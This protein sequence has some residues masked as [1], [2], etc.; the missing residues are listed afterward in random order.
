MIPVLLHGQSAG[1][2]YRMKTVVIDA[3]HGGKDP[4]NLGTGRYKW[5]EKNV[6]LDVTMK[7]GSYIKE[8]FPDINVIYTRD[9]DE[10][11]GLNERADIANSAK[12]DIFISIHCN[13]VEYPSARGVET[14]AL[15]LHRNEENLQVAMKENSAI[16]LEDDYEN[17]YD[18]F[19]PNSPESIIALTMMQSAF[20]DQSLRISSYIQKQFK[21][22]VGR[23]DRGVKQAGFLVLR[24]TTMPSIL[25]ELGFLTNP[26]EEDFLNSESGRVYMA[27]AIL[28]GFKEYKSTVEDPLGKEADKEDD[29]KIVSVDL[30]QAELKAEL[31]RK[32]AELAL[33]NG[34][35][36]AAEAAKIAK[37]D[38]IKVE[39][40]KKV[41]ASNAKK[42]ESE[43][44]AEV[45][46]LK[47]LAE[48]EK[49][50]K[51]EISAKAKTDSLA[52][53]RNKAKSAKLARDQAKV[54]SL[55]IQKDKI[56]AENAQAEAKKKELNR[57]AELARLSELALAEEKRLAE[58]AV[59]IEAA[60]LELTKEKTEAA[61]LAQDQA[62]V[63]SLRIQ[64]EKAAAELTVAASRK[65][66]ELD[67]IEAE[68]RKADEVNQ[69]KIESDK[70][71]AEEEMLQ[72]A[73]IR[74]E[75]EN[76]AKSAKQEEIRKILE[77]N[78][79]DLIAETQEQKNLNAEK[80]AAEAANAQRLEDLRK[81][82]LEIEA[83]LAK[84]QNG[85]LELAQKTV[86]Q[87]EIVEP[88]VEKVDEKISGT[89]GLVFKVQIHTATKP[90][91]ASSSLF[92][93]VQV[94]EY[95]QGDLYKYTTGDF[96]TVEQ[97]TPTQAKMRE[98]GFKGAFVVAFKDGQR[99][100]VSVARALLKQ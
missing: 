65:Q 98:L 25:I 23:K 21:E 88:V 18:G 49:Q 68:N 11:I 17:K 36:L 64:N 7:L 54:D 56:A 15:G 63:D 76:A 3:G 74:L 89:T 12:A 70:R 50:R 9:K 16:T 78:E 33:Q 85:N 32:K 26:E 51:L 48:A 43:R 84:L 66:L 55:R 2:P 38:S 57:I 14:F 34:I 1:Q 60:N 53:E 82:K 6:A 5:R 19:D 41:A 29:S 94:W 62:K 72:E 20:L 81:K 86:Y 67:R 46:R 77:A 24:K 58:N 40:E 45:A 10:F 99:I 69:A 52:F 28:R 92:Q 100:K 59:R 79:N 87:P 8:Q 90:I 96:S 42:K 75:K 61:K 71:L 80:L 83:R 97:A 22:R 37:Q 39:E 31:E 35:D 73:K 91:D 4:G 27:S 30:K 13:A 95:E 47:A 44:I 93:G